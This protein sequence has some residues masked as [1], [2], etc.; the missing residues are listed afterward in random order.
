MFRG[1]Q[2]ITLMFPVV[3]GVLAIPA[4]GAPGAVYTMTNSAGG[5]SVVMYSRSADGSLSGPRLFATG[6]SGSGAGLGSQGAVALSEDGQWLIAVNAGSNDVSVFSTKEGELTLTDREASGGLM[7]I[8]A[9]LYKDLVFVLNG[10]GSANI[11]GFRLTQA[12]ALVPIPGSTRVLPGAGPAQVSF[13]NHGRTLVVTEKASNTI[14][15]YTVDDG[16]V[17]G[18][19]TH[20]SSGMTPFGFGISKSDILVVSDAAGG[21]P[22]ASTV[23][24]YLVDE[25]G[26]LLAVTAA[27][28]TGQTAACWVAVTQ[29]GK[30]GYLANTGSSTISSVSIG[31]DGSLTLLSAVA[32]RTPR[33]TPAIDL[34]FSVDSRYLYSLAG[35]TISVFEASADG[36]L[37]SVQVVTGLSSSTVGLAAK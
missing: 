16:A 25:S 19:F 14:T 32:G 1:N 3:F 6:G 15:V 34:A 20:P 31:R 23:S 17:S 29:N 12:G 9:A 4:I 22:G 5:N 27:L 28:A 11:T 26:G 8:S 21:A 33:G 18:P 37:S 10:G 13:T 24:S 35:G 36:G 30:Y 2:G 7:P